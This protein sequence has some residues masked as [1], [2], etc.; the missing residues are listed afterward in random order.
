MVEFVDGKVAPT[1]RRWL[2]DKNM[3][4]LFHEAEP[5]LYFLDKYGTIMVG[6]AKAMG[7]YYK[8]NKGKT[9]LDKLTVSDIAY[10][11]MVYENSYDVWMEE[12]VKAVTCENDEEKRAFKRVAVNKYHV[13]RGSRI[14]LYQDGWTSEGH[15]YFGS[16]CA[17]IRD[18]MKAGELW[19]TLKSHWAT[20]AKKYHKYSYVCN[21]SLMEVNEDHE[22]TSVLSRYREKTLMIISLKVMTVMRRVVM[23]TRVKADLVRNNILRQYEHDADV[24]E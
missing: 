9:L 19:S 20:Y 3:L 16:I 12:I 23:T 8:A 2:A 13:K 1:A 10:S 15:E 22:D 11:I 4:P 24:I 5:F 6:G 18:M 21:K 7:K 14:A 17:E